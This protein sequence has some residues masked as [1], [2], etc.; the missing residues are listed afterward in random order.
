MDDPFL[1]RVLNG[2]RH[3]NEERETLRNAHATLGAV[4]RDPN[5]ADQL[6]HEIWSSFGCSARIKYLR[7]VWVVQECENLPLRFEPCD[8]GLGVH[9]WFD[10]LQRDVSP[11]GSRLLGKV[12]H[13][14][15]TFA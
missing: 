14:T 13:T 10:D 1:V 15:A 2:L 8:D 12:G 11:D 5:P 4:L 3:L 7:N 9:P 6:H